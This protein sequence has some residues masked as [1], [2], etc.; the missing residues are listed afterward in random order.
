MSSLVLFGL[1]LL[2]S[3]AVVM[4]VL[5]L[6]FLL[7]T[8]GNDGVQSGSTFLIFFSLFLGLCGLIISCT[9]R[10]F[11]CMMAILLGLSPVELLAYFIYAVGGW[12]PYLSPSSPP[13]ISAEDQQ[14][15]IMARRE[16]LARTYLAEQEAIARTHPY[17]GRDST[18]P[19][20]TADQMPSLT[21]KAEYRPQ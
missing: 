17:T 21:G 3:G 20:Y 5:V 10:C 11:R 12:A 16:A 2:G 19:F 7:F 1:C 9:N 6:E 14:A 4:A 13:Q 8:K 18:Q 15:L